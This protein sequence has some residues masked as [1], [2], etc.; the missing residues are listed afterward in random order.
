MQLWGKKTARGWHGQWDGVR[1]EKLL[2]QLWPKA[3]VDSAVLR[4][5][6]RR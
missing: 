1:G 3:S 4:P 6:T 5:G 2:L